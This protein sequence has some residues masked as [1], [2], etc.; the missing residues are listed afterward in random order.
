[1]FDDLKLIGKITD[2]Y[3][4]QVS[5]GLVHGEPFELLSDAKIS[6]M[7]SVSCKINKSNEYAGR[8]VWSKSDHG[9]LTLVKKHAVQINL[10]CGNWLML[11]TL[12]M[13][14]TVF[15]VSLKLMQYQQRA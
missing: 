11:A 8:I 9:L 12:F 10:V 5:T 3:G 6:G 14:K 1:M 2:T 15:R 13:K 7:L 4:A